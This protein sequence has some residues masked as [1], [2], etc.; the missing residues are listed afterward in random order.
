MVAE[1]RALLAGA[2][3]RPPYVLVG[4]SL[5]VRVV[6]V[7]AGTYR[8]EVA[9]LV[10]VD[11]AQEELEVR[12]APFLFDVPLVVLM[13][14]GR[15]A[16]AARPGLGPRRRLPAGDPG[17]RRGDGRPSRGPHVIAERS[18]HFVPHDEPELARAQ[19]R[20]SSGRRGPTRRR[21]R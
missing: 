8:A 12:M 2:R 1:L 14:A 5:G 18:G 16:G 11:G 3:V 7:F 19:S 6:R 21:S 4:R 13:A 17:H 9:G 10:L 15:G 20:R